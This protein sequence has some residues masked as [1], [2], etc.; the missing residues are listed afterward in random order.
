MS[1]ETFAGVW[2]IPSDHAVP[3]QNEAKVLPFVQR[4]GHQHRSKHTANLCAARQVLDRP[5]ASY[6][7]RNL[8]SG[9]ET[10]TT[11]ILETQERMYAMGDKV[12]VSRTCFLSNAARVREGC[13]T[14]YEVRVGDVTLEIREP[15]SGAGRAWLSPAS[16]MMAMLYMLSYIDQTDLEA[17]LDAVRNDAP[18]P[19]PP[20]QH[21]VYMLAE[22]R[23]KKRP[24]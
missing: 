17:I 18:P 22:F 3:P 11:R 14:L 13:A 2:R 9:E 21:N 1:A 20:D 12:R 4:C 15:L 24:T 10:I 7:W 23:M 16:G 5:G 6:G 8:Q 19:E